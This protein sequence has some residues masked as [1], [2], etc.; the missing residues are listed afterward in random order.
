MFAGK[1]ALMAIAPVAILG[2]AAATGYLL[3]SS[4]CARRDHAPA[5]GANPPDPAS[6][7]ENHTYVRPAGPGAMT[8]P[9]EDT[10]TPTDEASDKSFPASDP[11]ANY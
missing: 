5:G 3:I 8:S 6:R 11:P 10:W 4:C 9:P 7:D 1:L 2:A